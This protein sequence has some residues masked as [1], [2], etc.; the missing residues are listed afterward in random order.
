MD[1]IG[2]VKDDRLI[3]SPKADFKHE[4][5]KFK[6]KPFTL[7]VVRRSRSDKANRYYWACLNYCSDATGYT[8]DEWHEAFKRSFL[9]KEMKISIGGVQ[10]DCLPTQHSTTELDSQEFTDYVE[11]IRD[12]ASK[13]LQIYIP[14]SEEYWEKV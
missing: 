14:T 7:K 3:I 1:F 5:G 4:V 8:S 13:V 12:Y 9:D 2:Q 10:V 11:K 6:G